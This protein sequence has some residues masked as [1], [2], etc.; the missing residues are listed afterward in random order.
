[1]TKEEITQKFTFLDWLNSY[2]QPKTRAVYFSGVKLFLRCVYQSDQDTKPLADRY[3]SEM[4]NGQR[5]YYRD[6]VTFINSMSDKPPTSIRTH[7][8]GTRNF[9]LYCCNIDQALG[10]VLSS[11][12]PTLKKDI[13]L[14][15]GSLLP[16]IPVGYYA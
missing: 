16:G 6:L 5:V 11:D 8:A 15:A 1:M 7:L 13:G 9:L 4:E 14:L 10:K 3:I 2:P 12:P